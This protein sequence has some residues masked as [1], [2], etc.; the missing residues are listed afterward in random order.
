MVMVR[1]RKS[2]DWL[3]M[4]EDDLRDA[5][6]DYEAG[7][8]ASAVYHA[9]LASQKALKAIITALGFEPIK[10]HKPTLQLKGLI[11]GGLIQLEKHI[12]DKLQNIISYAIS[13][14]DQ[15]TIP[16]Y[17]WETVNRIIKPSE[18]Y[19]KEKA[20][21]L[22]DNAEYVVRSISDILGEIDC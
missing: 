18:I 20:R 8:Y 19:D 13:L 2:L 3:S 10:T 21:A 11:A 5:L 6:R 12:M 9:E 7:S 15:G 22:L 17:G 14:E 1:S 4:A 16:R